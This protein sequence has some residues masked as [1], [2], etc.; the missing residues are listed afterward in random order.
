MWHRKHNYKKHLQLAI[1]FLKQLILHSITSW[2][3][4]E[5]GHF[6]SIDLFYGVPQ[7][8]IE[9][10]ITHMSVKRTILWAVSRKMK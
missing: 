4:N 2:I 9:I 10:G 8:A 6:S 3:F 1:F 7:R 5:L